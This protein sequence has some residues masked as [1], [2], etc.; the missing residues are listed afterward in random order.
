MGINKYRQWLN[1]SKIGQYL[2]GTLAGMCIEG[3]SL[4]LG[5]KAKNL[6]Y[7]ESSGISFPT[8]STQERNGNLEQRLGEEEMYS[9]TSRLF[10]KVEDNGET[11]YQKV[12]L[13]PI[14]ENKI[15]EIKNPVGRY[16]ANEVF[17]PKAWKARM[18]DAAA[19]VTIITPTKTLIEMYLSGFTEQ[20]FDYAVGLESVGHPGLSLEQCADSRSKSLPLYIFAR[21]IMRLKALYSQKV[22]GI[23]A[24]SSNIRKRLCNYSFSAIM[25]IG[26][27]SGILAATGADAK[28]IA[29][30][31]TTNLLINSPITSLVVLP[32]VEKVQDYFGTTPEYRKKKNLENKTQQI[33]ELSFKEKLMNGLAGAYSYA[34]TLGNTLVNGVKGAYN[35]TCNA[36]G[37]LSNSVF[38]NPGSYCKKLIYSE[39]IFLG[40]LGI[41]LD[42]YQ[43]SYEEKNKPGVEYRVAPKELDNTWD[44]IHLA[45]MA[46]TITGLA[47]VVNRLSNKNCGKMVDEMFGINEEI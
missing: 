20:I 40:G 29:C 26:V 22:W 44:Y 39:L 17:N 43:R 28:K 27:Y 13:I 8:R 31:V 34:S 18:V 14:L 24:D 16:V 5:Q 11:K 6:F 7:D 19:L 25:N 35:V 2:N 46:T 4:N 3:V 23:N 12:D 32:F 10:K 37:N 47:L 41:T 1:D 15:K 36:A 33:P 9:R 38:G 21:E 45:G 30:T 42:S